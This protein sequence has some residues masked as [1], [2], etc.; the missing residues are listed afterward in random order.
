MTC[1]PSEITIDILP[2]FYHEYD[3]S[4]GNSYIYLSPN[5]LN[6]DGSNDDDCQGT[7]RVQPS[8]PH[9][10]NF[11]DSIFSNLSV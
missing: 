8:W 4:M 2:E 6:A 1:N 3:R 7:F 9:P 5:A 10:E 11:S